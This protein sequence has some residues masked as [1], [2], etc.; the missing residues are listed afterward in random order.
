MGKQPKSK[1]KMGKKTKTPKNAIL[2][3]D[4]TKTPT[5]IS[6]ETKVNGSPLTWRFSGADETHNE[7][8]WHNLTPEE[9]KKL[10][11]CLKKF[12]KM[13]WESILRGGS[14]PIP[15]GDLPKKT[16]TRIVELEKD[17][18]E[19]IM[20]FRIQGNLP[21]AWFLRQGNLMR[22]LWWDPKHTVYPKIK[23]KKKKHQR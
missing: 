2:V 7:W 16:Y 22:A 15:L 18:W 20:S 17:D 3:S 21:R 9:L 4:K 10:V 23:G 19:E 12:E 5:S 8:G 14:H 6:I 1:Y 13:S 11:E